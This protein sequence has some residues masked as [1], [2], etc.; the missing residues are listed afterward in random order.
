MRNLATPLGPFWIDA[1]PT[2]T[3]IGVSDVT[4]V[5]DLGPESTYAWSLD[6]EEALFAAARA[7]G[8]ELDLLGPGGWRLLPG[9]SLPS[10]LAALAACTATMPR[11]GR[12]TEAR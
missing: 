9:G 6:Q 2:D 1:S 3:R 11:S 12:K 8:A 5:D 4:V 7:V 10:F